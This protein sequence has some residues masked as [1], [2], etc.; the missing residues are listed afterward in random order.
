VSLNCC[1]T[2]CRYI[3]ASK[4]RIYKN[5]D[6]STTLCAQRTLVYVFDSILKLLHPYMPFVTEELW[7]VSILGYEVVTFFDVGV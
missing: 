3:E 5:E 7:Q 4:T 1:T 2:S 6:Q